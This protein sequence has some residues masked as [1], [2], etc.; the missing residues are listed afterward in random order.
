[1][2]TC[3][4]VCFEVASVSNNT[5]LSLTY[6]ESPR[7]A[8]VDGDATNNQLAADLPLYYGLKN[9]TNCVGAGFIR[10]GFRFLSIRLPKDPKEDI[11]F[12]DTASKESLTN[13]SKR[14]P[15][16][17]VSLTELWVNCTAFPSNPNPRA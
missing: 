10:G 4:S 5:F 6:S 9:G 17:S 3:S 13:A 7:F 8:T 14:D 1:M 15:G 11:G 16:A 2:L 12:W